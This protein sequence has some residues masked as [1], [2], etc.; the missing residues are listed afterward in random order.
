[1]TLPIVRVPAD[2]RAHIADWRRQGLRVALVPTM[3]AL[4]EGHLT[5]VRRG[6]QQ[7]DRVVATIFVNPTQFGPTEDFARYP[8]DEAGDA[9]KLAS[10]G[11]DLL[12]APGVEGMY[13]AGFATSIDVG[14]VT[15]RWEGAF[16]PGHFQ[17]VATVVAKLLL[18]AAPDVACFG[19][20]DYQQLCTIRQLVRD[21]DIPVVIDGVETVREADGL[22]LS[23]RNAYLSPEQRAVAAQLNRVMRDVIA[24][25]R[26][27]APVEATLADG[28]A[29]ILAAGFAAVDYLAYVDAQTLEPLDGFSPDAGRL[30]CTARLGPVRL[31]DNMA[32]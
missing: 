19:Q 18:Q 12:F 29:R 10:A 28:T 1:M 14:P 17:G 27:G 2:L 16:R 20:K 25:L 23:S 6:R 22:A 3:G 32:V 13:P 15:S 26:A 9:A 24:L 8:R 5:L 30:I 4:H 31:L 21:L 11:C 7:A